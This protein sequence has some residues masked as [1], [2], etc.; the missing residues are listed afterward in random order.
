MKRIVKYMP[1]LLVLMLL[2]LGSGFFQKTEAQ[3]GTFSVKGI[4][5][6]CFEYADLGLNDK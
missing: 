5:V 1:M 6:S 4:W 2:S 3:A